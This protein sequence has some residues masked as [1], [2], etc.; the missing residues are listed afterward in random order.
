MIYPTDQEINR[1]E[2]S[3]KYASIPLCYGDQNNH[4]IQKEGETWLRVLRGQKNTGLIIYRG[5]E[6]E[7]IYAA[8]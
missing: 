8:L 6:N 5:K 3:S 2:V 7:Q 4:Q 1:T